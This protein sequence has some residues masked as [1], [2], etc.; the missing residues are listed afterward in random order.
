MSQYARLPIPELLRDSL[1]LYTN[2][3]ADPE[4]AEALADPYQYGPEDYAAG[5]ALR[6]AVI[7]ASGKKGAEA[8]DSRKAT[9]QAQDAAATLRKRFGRHRDRLRTVHKSGSDGY[10]ALKLSGRVPGDR[11][12]MVE[13][14]R[15]LY[16]TLE[17]RPELAEKVRGLTPAVVAESQALVLASQGAATTQDREQGEAKTASNTYKDA[18]ADL[19]DHAGE[20]AG[21]AED[22]LSD[23]PDLLA[24]L[25]L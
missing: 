21:V 5:L 10:S 11:E 8:A 24:K 25:G 2:A 9:G 4:I 18:V 7:D 6:Q 13:A 16:A 22:A 1:T 23:R 14:A 17:G 12:Q 20:M 19:R 15:H 3:G